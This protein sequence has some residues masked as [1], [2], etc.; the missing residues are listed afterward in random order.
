[1]NGSHGV[2]SARLDVAAVVDGRAP[3]DVIVDMTHCGRHVTGLERIALDLF[4]DGRL[5]TLRAAHVSAGSTLGMIA[6]QQALLPWRALAHPVPRLSARTAA[7]AA[8]Q[9]R[10]ALHP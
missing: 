9:P 6:A 10:A 5:G 8:W 3:P 2:R 4:G 7:D 1:M